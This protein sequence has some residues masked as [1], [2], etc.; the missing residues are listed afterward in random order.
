MAGPLRIA[1][2]AA[3]G[4]PSLAELTGGRAA[5]GAG[6][7]GHD[8]GLCCGHPGYLACYALGVVSY[9]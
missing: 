1:D 8:D 3:D 4:E 6:H 5:L 7:A 9:I 2:D